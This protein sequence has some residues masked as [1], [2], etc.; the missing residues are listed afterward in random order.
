MTTGVPRDRR[1]EFMCGCKDL[2]IRGPRR[3]LRSREVAKH[4]QDHEQRCVGDGVIRG[5]GAVGVPDA[6]RGESVDVSPVEAGAGGGEDPDG[7]REEGDEVLVP[8]TH[9]A[10]GL[11]VR[12]EDGG[13]G[14][15]SVGFQGLDEGFTIGGVIVDDLVAVGERAVVEVM[16]VFD[17]VSEMEDDR[18]RHC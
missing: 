7:R 18:L 14:A 13:E 11:E 3:K 5:P 2:R 16:I 15:V 17:G 1:D 8:G 4:A 10:A 12:A 9:F 6:A